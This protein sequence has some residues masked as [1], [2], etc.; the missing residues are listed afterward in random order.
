MSWNRVSVL[1]VLAILSAAAAWAEPKPSKI[2]VATWNL[3]WFSVRGQLQASIGDVITTEFAVKIPWQLANLQ[4][5]PT[6]DMQRLVD[7]LKDMDNVRPLSRVM[8]WFDYRIKQEDHGQL[9]KALDKAFDRVVKG[10]LEIPFVQ[11]WRSP[12][13][14]LDERLRALSS[15]WLRWIPKVLLDALDAEDLLPLVLGQT[16]GPSSP[17]EDRGP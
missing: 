3:E 9:R 4:A 6:V 17:D 16:G 8:E 5:R 10:L 1:Q 15:R 12:A 2:T 14:H 7:S 13:T 11:Q